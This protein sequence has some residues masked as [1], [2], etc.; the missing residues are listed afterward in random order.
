MTKEMKI[1][2]HQA[3]MIGCNLFV[4]DRITLITYDERGKVDEK[5]HYDYDADLGRIQV[6]L[7]NIAQPLRKKWGGEFLE[8][9]SVA[10]SLGYSINIGDYSATLIGTTNSRSEVSKEE[11]QLLECPFSS[12]GLHKMSDYLANILMGDQTDNEE[13]DEVMENELSIELSPELA[14]VIAVMYYRMS[15]KEQQDLMSNADA[16]IVSIIKQALQISANN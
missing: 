1:L 11:I 2:V 8:L 16:K 12:A 6:R 4:G 7:N 14:R 10:F 3:K 5:Y 13:E 15:D 9:S